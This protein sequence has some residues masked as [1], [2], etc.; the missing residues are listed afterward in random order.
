MRAPCI[1]ALALGGLLLAV[2]PGGIF[3]AESSSCIACH[4]NAD[5]LGED[6]AK[7]V[8]QWR[9][10]VHADVGLDCHDCHGGNPDPS[11]AEDADAAMDPKFA[12]NPFLGASTARRFG[13]ATPRSPPASTVTASTASSVQAT[14]GPPSTR[15]GSSTPAG[16]VTGIRSG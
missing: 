7:I 3:A 10:G 14:P 5:L 16:A 1:T 8:D 15:S 9:G 6:M 12:G 13:R 2:G 4:G 11:L